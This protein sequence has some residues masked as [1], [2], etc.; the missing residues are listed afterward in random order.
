MG[1][2]NKFRNITY[3]VK[4]YLNMILYFQS[5]TLGVL[6]IKRT[7]RFLRVFKLCIKKSMEAR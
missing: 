7:E 1:F 3:V 2:K 6:K 5:N 4:I